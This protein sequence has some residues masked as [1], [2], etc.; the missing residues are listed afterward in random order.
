[1]DV[2]SRLL[3]DLQARSVLAEVDAEA[4]ERQRG[5][6]EGAITIL[7]ILGKHGLMLRERDA[8]DVWSASMTPSGGE[9]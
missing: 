4:T 2:L 8:A 3:V 7:E 9:R 6:L 1:M 5:G